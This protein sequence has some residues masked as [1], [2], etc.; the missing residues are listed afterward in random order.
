MGY[1]FLGQAL[2]LKS[3]K[4]RSDRFGKITGV[5]KKKTLFCTLCFYH[6]LLYDLLARNRSKRQFYTNRLLVGWL[7]WV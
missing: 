6:L 5:A 2:L 1:E 7:F 4:I 3:Q